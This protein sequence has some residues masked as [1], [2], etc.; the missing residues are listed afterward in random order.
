MF[1]PK[2]YYK[3]YYQ[4][5]KDRF[6]YKSNYQKRI[7]LE[8]NKEYYKRYYQSLALTKSSNK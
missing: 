6:T 4:L 2:E 1:N 3:I 7:E 8:K 5:N